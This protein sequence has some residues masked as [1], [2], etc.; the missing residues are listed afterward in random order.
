[1]SLL[2]IKERIARKEA[3]RRSIG[4]FDFNCFSYDMRICGARAFRIQQRLAGNRI[5]MQQAL[6]G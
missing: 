6:R 3:N 1:M 2:E 4:W 5:T